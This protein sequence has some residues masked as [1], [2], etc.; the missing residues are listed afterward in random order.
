MIPIS[1]L[2][3]GFISAEDI[4]YYLPF[5]ITIDYGEKII[6]VLVEDETLDIVIEQENINIEA[7]QEDIEVILDQPNVTVQD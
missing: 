2:T 3:K 1:L 5:E 4:N 6:E 7:G